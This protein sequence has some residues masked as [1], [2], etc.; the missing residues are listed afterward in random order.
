[1]ELRGARYIH[2]LVP[3]PLGWGS[4]RATTRSGS[5]AWRAETGLFPVFEAEHGEVTRV[6]KIRR[7]LPVEEY[8][9][10]QQR[11]AHLFGPRRHAETHR[12]ASRPM[13]TSNIRALRAARRRGHLMTMQKPFAITLDPGSSLANKTGAWR[14]ERPVYVDRLP[15]CNHAAARPAKTSRAGC[16]TPRAATTKPRGATLTRD[17][18]FPAIMGRVCYHR[19]ESVVQPRPASTRRSASTRS[20]AFSA[21]RRSSAAGRFDAARERSGKRV[22]VV[23]AG[24]SGHVGRLPPAPARPRGDDRS[25]PGRSPAG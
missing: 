24:P 22:L 4:V 8:L 13:P 19:C 6:S 10:P 16:S 9:R 5:P 20:S 7:R 15:P 23:G 2:I 25:K 14:T 17:N 1:M 3:C 11:F 12:A 18:P 21:T